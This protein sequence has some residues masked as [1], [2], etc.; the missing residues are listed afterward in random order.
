VVTGSDTNAPVPDLAT[1]PTVTGE[2]SATVTAEP[3]ATDDCDGT[4]TGTTSDPLTYTGAGTY[5][6]HWTYTD[7]AGHTATQ[8][9]T[10]VVTDVTN[11]TIALVGASSITVECHTGFSDPGVTTTDN[12]V[13]EN[14]TVTTAGSVN[15][16]LPNTYT[17]TYTATDG[18]GNQASVDRTVI[19]QDT[20][21]PVITLNTPTSVPPV[22]C[23]TSFTDPG[24]TATDTCDTSVPVTVTGSVNVNVPGSY[25]L[26]YDA[27]DDSG[28][29]ATS[30]Q[31]TV[32]VVDTTPPTI[33]C[34]TNITVY[35]PLNTTATS[36]VVNY[37]APVGTDTCGTVTTTQT[38]GLP[39]GAS[40]PVGTTTNTFT[41]T[42]ASNNS[43]SCSF[44]VTVLYN[45]TGFFSP[46]GNPPTLNSVN[47]G[48]A[49]PVKFSLSGD[50][51]LNIFAPDNPY[52]VSFNCD[53]SDPGV[54]VVETVTAGG[55]SL[56]FGGDQYHY[57]W[58]T[59]SSWAGTCRQLVVTL[60]DGSVHTANFKF[61]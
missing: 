24:A 12:C 8:N 39:S 20:T 41:A 29:A 1:L 25:T 45:F 19:V 18:G 13:P 23:H 14:V 48:R 47:A 58:K 40:F 52:S 3:T 46:V 59:E 22:E 27:M 30:V 5:T 38:A 60:N 11:P 10:V 26:T 32:T 43:A 28:N 36:T 51:G 33:A 56:S 2:C 34:P 7:L 54:D 17:V 44:T 9:Q 15:I 50:K 4:L 61:R 37:T 6:V 55:S 16:N 49:I 31:R 42:D 35:L 53:T 57:V 21:K